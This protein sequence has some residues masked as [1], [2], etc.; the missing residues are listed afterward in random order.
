MDS[1]PSL[2]FKGSRIFSSSQSLNLLKESSTLKTIYSS[3]PL[4]DLPSLS[5]I[6]PD[7]SL[8]NT[9]WNSLLS[10]VSITPAI[11]RPGLAVSLLILFT[12]TL[13]F[14]PREL[15]PRRDSNRPLSE[16]VLSSSPKSLANRPV[17]AFLFFSSS[18]LLS[19]WRSLHSVENTV[20]LKLSSAF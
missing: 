7:S 3:R 18:F 6:S 4:T 2:F 9:N 17:P 20:S 1:T 14:S 8:P 15:A 12:M 13:N 16:S 5:T 19:S 11:A 10:A